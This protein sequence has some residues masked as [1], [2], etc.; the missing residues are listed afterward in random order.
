MNLI[1]FIYNKYMLGNS[2]QCYNKFIYVSIYNR[3]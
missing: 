2:L 1:I 3:I